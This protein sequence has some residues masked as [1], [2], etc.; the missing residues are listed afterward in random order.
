MLIGGECTGKSAL[1][2]ALVE[3]RRADGHTALVVPEALREFVDRA[4]RTPTADE[5]RAIL[6]SQ[7]DSVHAA[8]QQDVDLVVSD[9]APLMTAV[10]SIQYFDDRKLLPSAL[11]DL[12]SSDL[13]VWCA[14]DLPW[15][16]DGKHRDGPQ[17]RD[18]TDRILESQVI[19]LLTD[20]PLV[21]VHGSLA[22]RVETVIDALDASAS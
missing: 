17:A 9:P 3:A 13:I 6:T 16:P 19:P 7:K 21:Q 14:P 20:I 4:G 11:D 5:Q 15:Q 18:L 2:Q 12:E 1:A 10:Y 8:L 22:T